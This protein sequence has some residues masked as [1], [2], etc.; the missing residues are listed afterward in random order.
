VAGISAAGNYL[1]KHERIDRVLIPDEV[2]RRHDGRLT[3][4]GH[5]AFTKWR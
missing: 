4:N 2:P 3:E 5:T 1:L